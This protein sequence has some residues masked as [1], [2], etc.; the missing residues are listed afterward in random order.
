MQMKILY[1]AM[2][3]SLLLSQNVV[4]KPNITLT[5]QPTPCVTGTFSGTGDANWKS[6]V[7]KITNNCASA[8]DFQNATITF[9]NKQAVNTNAWGDFNPLSYPDNALNF[10]SQPANSNFLT[11]L[12]LHFPSYPGANSKLPAGKSIAIKYGVSTDTHIEGSTLVYLNN[13]PSGGSLALSNNSAQPA[14]VTQIYALVHLSMNG[15]KVSDIQLPW[16]SSQTISGL[17]AGAYAL[18]AD[19]LTDTNQNS[20]QGTV[21]PAQVT[22]VNNQTSSAAVTYTMVQQI[23]KLNISVQTMPVELVGYTSKPIVTL[24]NGG[25]TI[26]VNSDWNSTVSVPQ[27]K[28]N[29]SYAFSTSVINYNGVQC[30]PTFTPATLVASENTPPTTNL[31]YSCTQVVQDNIRLNISGAP[32]TLTSLKVTLT[33]NDNTAAVSKTIALN[34]GTGTDEVA[35]THGIIYNVS[36]DSVSGYTATFNPQPLTATAN[37]METITFTPVTGRIIG[38]AP[39]WKTPPSA[40]ALAQAG[41]T[42]IMVA[43]GVFSTTK[44]GEIVSAFD[45]IDATYI[46]SLHAAGIKV[47][48]SLG[49]AS[50][51]I[52][53]TSVDFHQVLSLATSSD[54]FKQTFMTSLQSMITQFG[55]DGFDI[56]IEQGLGVGG[57]FAQPQGDI[58]VLASIINTMHAQYPNLLITMAPQVANVSATSGFDQ[59]WGNYASLIMQTHDALTWV[60]IQLYNTGC[61]YGIDKIC[62]DSNVLTNPDF[63]VA[64]ATDLLENWPSKLPNGQI[65]G[66]QPYISYLKAT[67]VVLGYPSLNASG[68]SDG[69]PTPP[70]A[71]IKRA[72]QCLKSGISCGTYQPPRVYGNVGG[73]FNWEIT[74]DQSNNFKFATDLKNCVINGIC[75]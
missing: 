62:Y 30:I 32:T 18:S 11:S 17:A 14:N 16:Q 47:I 67:Q 71:I 65:S 41:Y 37:G 64:M 19:A 73:V 36:T 1:W 33:P 58:A 20:Y 61:A 75:N 13:A 55:F 35:L 9:I 49:G 42:H 70:A 6:M 4:A 38:Y 27:L 15:Q 21:T 26:T 46:Q 31:S 63:S 7:L 3:T 48:L 56:D 50:S 60:G 74:Y 40:T 54:A 69:S 66:F 12:N 45:T 5:P 2:A 28:A 44:P 68:Q 43:F 34:N 22:I 10:S 8:V 72:I 24:S 59:T 23:G 57:T 53:N 52:V 29:A 25:N 39:G 51:S